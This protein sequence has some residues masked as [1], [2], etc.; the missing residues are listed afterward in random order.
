MNAHTPFDANQDWTNPYC[1]NS[2][3]DPMVDALLGNAYHVVRTVYCNLGNLKLIYDF[4]NKYGMVLGVQSETELKAMPTSASYV[5]LYGFDNTNK[6]VVTD[7]LYV[8]GDRTGVIPDDPSAT[9]SWILVATSNSD[10][11]G[12]DG[13]GK[14]SPPYIPYSY[15]NGSAIGGETTIPVP[16]GTVGVPMIVIDGYTNLVGYGFTYDAASL[17]VTLAQPLE[18][19]D[20]VH[21]FLTGTPAVPDNPNVS[22]WVQINWLYNGGYASGGEQVIQIPYTFKSVPAIYKNGARYYSGLAE[23][24]YTVDAANQRILLTEP[25]ATNDRLIITIGGEPETLIMTDRTI[26]EVARSANVK[27]TEIILSTNTT[28]FLNGKKVIYDVAAQKMYGLPTLP[29]NVYIN[30]VSNGQLTYSPGNITVDLNPVPSSGM[31]A[32]NT[33]RA[34]LAS[35]NLEL[36]DNLLTVKQPFTGSIVRTQHFKNTDLI[37]VKDFGAVGDGVTDDADAFEAATAVAKSLYI[38]AGT[39]VL[40]HGVP[41]PLN[42]TMRGAGRHCTKIYIPSTFRLTDP[43]VFYSPGGENGAQISDITIEFYQ[44]DVTSHSGLIHYPAAFYMRNTPRFKINTVRIVKGWDGINMLGN[45]GGCVIDDLE[46]SCFNYDIVADGSL[47]SVKFTKLHIWPYGLV[48]TGSDNLYNLWASSSHTGL[49]L[50]R[51]DDLHLSDS[52]FFSLKKAVVFTT[53]TDGNAAFG[54]IVN[55]DFDDRGGLIIDNGNISVSNCFFSVGKADSNSIVISGGT[56]NISNSSFSYS[57]VPNATSGILIQGSSSPQVTITGCTFNCYHWDM[58]AVA[59]GNG[60]AGPRLAMSGCNFFKEAALAYSNPVIFFNNGQGTVTGCTINTNTSGAKPPFI[61]VATDVG[62][63]SSGNIARGY[64]YIAPTSA[65]LTQTR[66]SQNSV[67]GVN[68]VGG[69]PDSS[70][71][72]TF[73]HGLSQRPFMAIGTVSNS[74]TIASAQ[75][76]SATSTSMTFN[77]RGANG[78]ITTAITMFWVAFN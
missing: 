45:S 13:E 12:D 46:S 76:I 47:D 43:G 22:D 5:R 30:S 49:Q 27:D 31:D 40:S 15:N 14:A 71:N 73:N 8:E 10:S 44:P 7:Y 42:F 20:E 57:V 68:S 39:Y 78:P 21:L 60:T 4:L 19:G 64:G 36:G 2:S 69:T 65:T 77:I 24:S 56:V 3:N 9:G 66:L 34:D 17:T 29:T 11:G 51:V 50:G 63:S 53:G 38:P 37:S 62:V 1:R 58:I 6:R 75:F 25:L 18:P 59:I 67:I 72:L 74:G 48:N 61:S 35:G 28:Q 32:A 33:L 54:N 55:T 70:G 26:Q 23:N 16:A 41:V 52:L